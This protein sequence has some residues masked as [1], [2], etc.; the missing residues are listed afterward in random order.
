MV[1]VNMHNRGLGFG[2][3]FVQLDE[4]PRG[5]ATTYPE[6][7]FSFCFSPPLHWATRIFSLVATSPKFAFSP[8]FVYNKYK[9]WSE[10]K[11]SFTHNVSQNFMTLPHTTYIVLA[12]VQGDKWQTDY[13]STF[14]WAPT[15]S[16]EIFLPTIWPSPNLYLAHPP[17]TNW[18]WW[19]TTYSGAKTPKPGSTPNKLAF[20]K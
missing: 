15:K 2:K 17:K 8:N 16:V 1:F 18:K 14:H 13:T 9:E 7:N 5:L 12:P 4:N 11:P 6:P 19:P 3:W 20:A 10:A